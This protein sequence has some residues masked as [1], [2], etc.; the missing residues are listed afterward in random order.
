M[1]RPLRIEYEGAVYHIMSRGN[2]K[3]QIFYDERDF[4]K[5]SY[6]L[7]CVHERYEIIVYAYCLM[8]NHYHLLVETPH[9]NLS[10]IMRD[11]NGGYT[12]YFNT[13]HKRAGHLFQGRYKAI[14]VDKENYLLELSRYIHLNPVRK[15]I[16][17]KPEKYPYSSLAAYLAQD[18][19][20]PWM[21][22]VFLLSRFGSSIVEQREEY[23]R[24]IYDD[25]QEYKSI[26]KNIYAQS[27]IGSKD[28][29]ERIRKTFLDK[30][31]VSKEVPN[32][33]KL[34]YGKSLDDIAGAVIKYYKADYSLLYKRKVIHNRP[35]KVFVYLSRRYTDKTINQIY[36]Y[37]KGSISNNSISKIFSRIQDEIYKD[38]TLKE[39]VDI[40]TRM[41]L[42]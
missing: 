42:G 6:Y 19:I 10:S 7:G 33:K 38:K 1:A 24:F 26:A 30:R 13:R 39:E 9:A 21:N 23:K 16:V 28:F 32:I 22:V 8:E 29:I 27:I 4:K 37:L 34:K 2:E 15:K 20:R 36:N 31:V 3:R 18:V 40:V 12:M 5:F 41:L 14:L 17:N 35:K 11:L 25:S